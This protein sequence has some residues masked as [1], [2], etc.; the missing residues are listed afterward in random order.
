MMKGNIMDEGQP[1]NLLSLLT[2]GSVRT[3]YEECN[4]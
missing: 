4:I 3:Y 1:P 2:R